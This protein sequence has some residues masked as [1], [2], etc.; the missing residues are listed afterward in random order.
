MEH[1]IKVAEIPQKERLETMLNIS[2][3]DEFTGYVYLG[4]RQGK[5]TADD[6]RVVEYRQLFAFRKGESNQNQHTSGFQIEKLGCVSA[7]VWK[8]LQPGDLFKPYFDRYGKVDEIK[9]LK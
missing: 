2:L 1:F 7:E 3:P 8:D 5:F 4:N 6:G 9:K